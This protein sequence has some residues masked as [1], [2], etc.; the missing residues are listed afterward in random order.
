MK[1]TKITDDNF[2]TIC[3]NLRKIVSGKILHSFF[4]ETRSVKKA[5]QALRDVFSGNNSDNITRYGE[6]TYYL[7]KVWTKKQF[8]EDFQDDN[9]ITEKYTSRKSSEKYPLS[10]ENK[11]SIGRFVRII[12]SKEDKINIKPNRIFLEQKSDEADK[13]SP[14]QILIIYW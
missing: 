5:K 9:E 10:S 13:K 3:N 1:G 7:P 12:I 4:I 6:T 14:K 8:D 2:P 11:I